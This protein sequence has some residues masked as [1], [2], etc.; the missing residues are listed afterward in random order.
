MDA[1]AYRVELACHM[2]SDRESAKT[3]I[4]REMAMGYGLSIERA[5]IP[6]ALSRGCQ[7]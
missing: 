2:G 5:S 1:D 3:R 4:A 6:L 7:L